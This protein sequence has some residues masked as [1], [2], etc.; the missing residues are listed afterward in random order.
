MCDEWKNDF[1]KFYEWAVTH[2]YRDDLTL[3]RIDNS[4]GYT[5]EN[6]RFVTPKDQ[7][8]NRRTNLL[9]TYNGETK[10]LKQWTEYLGLNYHKI[11]H[12]VR[13]RGIPFEV[14][15]QS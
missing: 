4:K 15:I 9:F 13:E 1:S 2:G 3:D 10:T 12:R 14:A 7:A 5:P 11:Y 6:C 8:N